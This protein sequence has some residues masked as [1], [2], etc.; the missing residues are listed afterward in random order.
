[1]RKAEKIF[2]A[3]QDNGVG[4]GGSENK[5]IPLRSGVDVGA[6]GSDRCWSGLR[7]PRHIQRQGNRNCRAGGRA[8]RIIR[9]VGH[10]RDGHRSSSSDRVAGKIFFAG[11]EFAESDLRDLNRVQRTDAGS[12]VPFPRIG[13]V[14]ASLTWMWRDGGRPCRGI[15]ALAKRPEVTSRSR[16]TGLSVKPLPL[17]KVPIHCRTGGGWRLRSGNVS[18]AIRCNRD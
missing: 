7:V 17:H 16:V 14:G 13:V 18:H 4:R 1:M 15:P 10:H 11:T 12:G 2:N 5:K 8:D 6:L 3:Q 9:A